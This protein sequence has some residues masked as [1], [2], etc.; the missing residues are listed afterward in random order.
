MTPVRVNGSIG[1][2][3]LA[4]LAEL[5]RVAGAV[6][7]TVISSCDKVI[8]YYKD[9]QTNGVQGADFVDELHIQHKKN[10]RVLIAVFPIDE[11]G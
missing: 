5:C 10:A 2:K 7:S 1:V 6:G 9:P 11:V 3:T 8:V 4:E